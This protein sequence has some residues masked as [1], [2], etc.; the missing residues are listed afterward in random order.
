LARAIRAACATAAAPRPRAACFADGAVQAAA[1]GAQ[2]RGIGGVV[3]QRVAEGE[4]LAV[5]V[6]GGCDE[7][8]FQQDGEGVG[9]RHES[10]QGSGGL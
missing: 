9:S 5:G 2:Q 8:G 7:A 1:L 10:P 4:G 6:F 3:Q